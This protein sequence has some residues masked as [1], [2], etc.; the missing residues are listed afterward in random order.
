MEDPNYQGAFHWIPSDQRGQFSPW[1][2]TARSYIHHSNDAWIVYSGMDY[3]G[4][5]E[6]LCPSKSFKNGTVLPN[7]KEAQRRVSNI[8][9]TVG[10]VQRDN[11]ERC[12]CGHGSKLVSNFLVF[13]LSLI[14]VR[15]LPFGK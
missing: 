1:P 12:L 7:P 5:E 9:I 2:V 11:T 13:I 3:S 4:S 10:S 6:C 8:N 14:F 15:V